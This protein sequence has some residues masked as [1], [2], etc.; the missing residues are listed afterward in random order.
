[1]PPKPS[2]PG[3]LPL[4]LVLGRKQLGNVRLFDMVVEPAFDISELDVLVKALRRQ[5]GGFT[6]VR[7]AN[8]V[9]PSSCVRCGPA[10]RN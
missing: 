6:K 1:M 3:K 10:G 2:E 8:C 4:R 7:D 9:L 5:V